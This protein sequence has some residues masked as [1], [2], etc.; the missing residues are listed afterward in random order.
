M[1]TFDEVLA[2]ATA[3]HNLDIGDMLVWGAAN[4]EVV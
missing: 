3:A 4:K 1:K 2:V